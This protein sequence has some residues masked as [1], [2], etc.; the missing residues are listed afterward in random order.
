MTQTEK[1][2]G[3]HDI[4]KVSVRHWISANNTVHTFYDVQLKNGKHKKFPVD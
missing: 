2:F 3:L 1:Y 4:S